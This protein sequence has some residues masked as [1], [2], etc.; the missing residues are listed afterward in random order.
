MRVVRALII[1]TVSDDLIG[2]RQD[3]SSANG[4]KP[5]ALLL[6]VGDSVSTIIDL[7]KKLDTPAFQAPNPLPRLKHAWQK[8]LLRRSK[9]LEDRAGLD[10]KYRY[11]DSNQFAGRLCCPTRLDEV[12]KLIDDLDQPMGEQS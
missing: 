12:R 11:P 1:E 2:G 6:L 5:T 4:V 3:V 7:A 10:P 9:L 8:R